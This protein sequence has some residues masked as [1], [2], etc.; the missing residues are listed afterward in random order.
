[1]KLCRF[2]VA[3]DPRPRAG[4]FHD[5]KIYETDGEKALG[6]HAPEA[7]DL[8]TPIGHAASLRLFDAWAASPKPQFVYG[9]PGAIAPP[10]HEILFPETD[11]AGVDVYMAVVVG[12]TDREVTIE[13]ADQ[14]V[15]GYS[16]FLA[17][18]IGDS[19]QA[20]KLYDPGFI[21][22]PFVVTPDE[23]DDR[24]TATERGKV[25]NLK[26]RL[27]LGDDIVANVE[28]GDMTYTFAEMVREASRGADLR[29]GDIIAAG[30]IPGLSLPGAERSLRDGDVVIAVIEKLGAL[31]GRA[32]I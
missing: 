10:E 8:L 3:D 17:W 24:A 31:A 29:E 7:V 12:S 22:G 25:F 6:V 27:H 11:L 13:E 21:L 5:G 2:S 30:P 15:L 14:L 19:R 32:R 20:S 1:M 23:M 28:M 4:I 9:N 16:T 26:C 18:S